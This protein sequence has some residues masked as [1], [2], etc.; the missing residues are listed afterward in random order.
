MK[1]QK[2]HKCQHRIAYPAKI[3]ISIDGETKIF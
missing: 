1:T 3:S 2:E